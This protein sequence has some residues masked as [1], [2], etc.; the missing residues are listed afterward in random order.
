MV[1]LLVLLHPLVLDSDHCPGLDNPSGNWFQMLMHS[2]TG[3]TCAPNSHVIQLAC[4]WLPGQ[5]VNFKLSLVCVVINTGSTSTLALIRYFKLG[6]VWNRSLPFH[7]S[8]ILLNSN[9]PS[10]ASVHQ[11][12]LFKYKWRKD[13]V[14]S[15][16][17]E[18]VRL[19]KPFCHLGSS[20]AV[21]CMML[22]HHTGNCTSF[23]APS[24]EVWKQ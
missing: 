17:W 9:L 13:T 19:W 20:H 11:H 22:T 7:S 2:D 4:F 6:N 3:S 21:V 16:E 14:F 10:K 15:E 23:S 8:S 12:Q 24:F 5:S 1:N 18:T